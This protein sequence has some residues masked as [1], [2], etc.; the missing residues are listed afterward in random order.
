MQI[1]AAS[2][3]AVQFNCF[4]GFLVGFILTLASPDL[5]QTV[6]DRLSLGR[7][8]VI[9]HSEFMNTVVGLNCAR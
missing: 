3:N 1:P 8:C 4:L 2:E 5:G 9:C 7:G 6:T